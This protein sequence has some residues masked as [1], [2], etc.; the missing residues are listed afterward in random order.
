MVFQSLRHAPRRHCLKS[1]PK[2]KNTALQCRLGL[3]QDTDFAGDLKDSESTSGGLLCIFGSQTF[4]PISWMSKKQ[5][6]VSHS[7]TETEIISLDAGLRMD[8]VPALDL[9][10]LVIEVF[11]SSPNQINKS[12]GLESQGSLSRNTTLHMKNQNSTKHVNLDLKMLITFR[13]T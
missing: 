4:V 12:T 2:Q 13:P 5:T 7:S 1:H 3:F 11:H 9:W 6:S 8:G 10:D